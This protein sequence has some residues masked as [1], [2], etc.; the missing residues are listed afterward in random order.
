MNDYIIHAIMARKLDPEA[1]S[2]FA[3][4]LHARQADQLEAQQSAYFLE[5]L[6][7]QE[8]TVLVLCTELHEWFGDRSH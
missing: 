1:A 4:E 5:R 3:R 2:A 7:S 6:I 8:D